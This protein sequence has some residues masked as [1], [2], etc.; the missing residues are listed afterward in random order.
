M[1]NH[2]PDYLAPTVA[3]LMTAHPGVEVADGRARCGRW[4]AGAEGGSLTLSAVEASDDS[5]DGL[6]PLRALTVAAWTAAG[7]ADRQG[8]TEQPEDDG[9]DLTGR[10]WQVRGV[11]AAAH[12]AVERLELD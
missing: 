10:D 2:R 3:G 1:P 5:G 8:P 4:V 9:N 6:D 7:T 11:G 12:E